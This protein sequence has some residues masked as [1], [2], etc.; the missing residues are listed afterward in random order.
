MGIE[1]QLCQISP[2]DQLY[3]IVPMVSNSVLCTQKFSKRM[4]LIKCSNH[5]KNNK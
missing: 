5:L 1:S 4:Y 2:R 3:T